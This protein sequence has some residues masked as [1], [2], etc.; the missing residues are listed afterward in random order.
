[1]AI[2][3]AVL[4]VGAVVVVAVVAGGLLVLQTGQ[5]PPK[6][7]AA[8]ASKQVP[9]TAPLVAVANPPAPAP[10]G[11]LAEYS[12][13]LNAEVTALTTAVDRTREA[14]SAGDVDTAVQSLAEARTHYNHIAPVLPLL[15]DPGSNFNGLYA[16]LTRL[17]E[18]VRNATLVG[19]SSATVRLKKSAAGYSPRSI[20]LLAGAAASLETLTKADADLGDM[21]ATAEGIHEIATVYAGAATRAGGD[22]A[23]RLTADGEGL[24]AALVPSKEAGRG[25]DRALI[26]TTAKALAA[27]F[28][29]LATA[30]GI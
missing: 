12:A 16:A 23:A 25:P 11:P 10:R 28:K 4:I 21:T 22:I 26:Q 13:Y 3:R 1:M 18:G 17:P 8:A 20:D 24:A 7:L 30:L 29:S 2:R 9:E 19:L 14:S 27:D 15:V 5:D 6:P